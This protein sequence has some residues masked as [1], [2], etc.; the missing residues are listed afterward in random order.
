MNGQRSAISWANS[1]RGGQTEEIEE[2]LERI[3][4]EVE[5]CDYLQG[6]QLCHSISRATGSGLTSSILTK[7]RE[8]FCSKCVMTFT[9][10]PS[11]NMAD[12]PVEPYNAVLSFHDLIHS[13]DM[14]VCFDNE[15]LKGAC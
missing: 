5:A 6:F 13:T 3:R 10:M 11:P 15:A 7:I 1:I 4:S 9:V 8:E 2:I 12:S 14:T